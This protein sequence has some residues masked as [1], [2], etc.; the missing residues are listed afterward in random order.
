MRLEEVV[1]A[2]DIVVGDDLDD[3][4]ESDARRCAGGRA[5]RRIVVAGV[6]E[7]WVVEHERVG[8]W[9]LK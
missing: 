4:S 8:E 6:V 5:V 2:V 3:L 7:E 1:A 9:K